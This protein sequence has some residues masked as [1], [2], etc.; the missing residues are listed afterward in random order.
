MISAIR[1]AG[2]AFVFA[3]VALSCAVRAGAQTP[4]GSGAPAGPGAPAGYGPRFV[5]PPAG[6]DPLSLATSRPSC[7][8]AAQAQ[9]KPVLDQLR[10]SLAAYQAKSPLPQTDTVAIVPHVAGPD[11]SVPYYFEIRP[12]G[13]PPGPPGAGP[14]GGFAPAGGGPSPAA[15]ASGMTQNAPPDGANSDQRAAYRNSPQARAF[16]GMLAC[17]YVTVYSPEEA[18]AKAIV[19]QGRRPAFFYVP[20][21]G[22]VTVRPQMPPRAQN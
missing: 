6:V 11:P 14:P 17:A 21:V 5:P 20:N 8:A 2:L 10:A 4:G 12:S 19:V 3:A 1:P 18:L 13:M 15:Q 22:I 9:A 16:R 7:D